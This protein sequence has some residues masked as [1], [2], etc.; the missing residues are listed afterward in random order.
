MRRAGGKCCANTPPGAARQ[1]W[2]PLRTASPSAPTHQ[3]TAPLRDQLAQ[4]TMRG[5]DLDQWQ[6]EITGAG[7]IWYALD[8]EARTVWVTRAST[9]H[10]KATE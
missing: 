7:R 8:D 1:A 6:F 4:R 9:G 3:V 2:E 10:P 5:R